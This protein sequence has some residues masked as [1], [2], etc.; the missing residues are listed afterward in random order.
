VV[1]M[2]EPDPMVTNIC[3]GGPDMIT[4]YITSSGRGRLYETTWARPGLKLNY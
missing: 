3:F 4:A 1:N 2:P